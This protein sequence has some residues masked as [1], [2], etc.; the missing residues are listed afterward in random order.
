MG[1]VLAY[2]V[3]ARRRDLSSFSPRE[4][5]Y[6]FCCQDVQHTLASIVENDARMVDVCDELDLSFFASSGVTQNPAWREHKKR[7]EERILSANSLFLFGGYVAVLANRLNFFKL[8]GAFV[9]ALQRGTCFYAVSAGTAVLSRSIILY[10]DF[11]DR[12]GGSSEFEFFDNGF[13]ILSGVQV[14]PHCNDRI[15]TDDPENLAYLARRFQ[16]SCCVGL[17]QQSFLLVEGETDSEGHLRERF[18][19]LGDK[20]GVYVFDPT[21]RKVVRRKGEVVDAL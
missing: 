3:Q 5:Q 11:A 20:D 18:T 15:K 19:S 17:N 8:K 13:G 4:L 2:P 14:F 7:L 9:E 1:R 21:G 16:S 10:N 6:H 12:H